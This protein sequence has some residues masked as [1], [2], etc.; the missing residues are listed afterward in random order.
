MKTELRFLIA[1]VAL[2]MLSACGAKGPLFMPEKPPAQE[3]TAPVAAP[4]SA[5]APATAPAAPASTVPET[6]G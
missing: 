1:G 2:A 4:A 3:E 6:H 5:A